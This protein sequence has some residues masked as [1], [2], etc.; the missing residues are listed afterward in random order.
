MTQQEIFDA[1]LRQSAADCS[2]SPEDFCRTEHV[3]RESLPSADARKDRPNPAVCRLVSFGSNI[4]AACRKDLIPEVTAYINSQPAFHRCLETPF[5]YELNKSLE[6]A[7]ARV[8]KMH[9][10]F[11]PDPEAVFGADLDC[12]Y[13]TRVLRPEDFRDLYVPAWG[14]ALCAE[15]Y[16]TL[17]T[18]AYSIRTGKNVK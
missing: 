7:G 15:R 1:A 14:N 12:P 11:L 9:T 5:F 8:A 6:K 18:S 13:E 16:S 3:V 4:V 2:C 10:A 17:T